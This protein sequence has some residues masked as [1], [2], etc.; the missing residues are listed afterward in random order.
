MCLEGKI[1]VILNDGDI[2]SKILLEKNEGVLVTE[3][4]WDSQKFLTNDSQLIVF[5]STNY[6]HE[7]YIFD[8]NEFVKIKKK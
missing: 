4:I 6:I 7:D 3:L 5:C 8:F 1:E 2:E